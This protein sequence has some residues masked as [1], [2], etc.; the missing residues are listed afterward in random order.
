MTEPQGHPDLVVE[1]PSVSDS[2]PS[3]GAETTVRNDGEGTAA[4]TTLSYFLSTD[5]TI[6]TS[7]T[8]LGMVAIAGLAGRWI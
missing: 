1:S 7:D 8:A 4:G 3:A 2:G 6:T 5:T